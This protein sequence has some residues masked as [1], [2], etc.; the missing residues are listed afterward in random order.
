MEKNQSYL[1]PRIQTNWLRLEAN[2][3]LTQAPGSRTSLHRID[4]TMEAHSSLSALLAAVLSSL[5]SSVIDVV[6]PPFVNNNTPG[7]VKAHA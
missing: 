6:S 5:D 2:V 4:T 7:R 1:D 3:D